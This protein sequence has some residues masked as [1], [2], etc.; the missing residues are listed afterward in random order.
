[1][2]AVGEGVQVRRHGRGQGLALTGLHLGDV[3]LVQR[4][5][6][7]HL[8]VEVPLPDRP[9]RGLPDARERLGQQV[10][11]GLPRLEPLPELGRLGR[12][13][14][15][16]QVLDLGLVRVDQ[17]GCL[18][19]LLPLAAFAELPELLDDHASPRRGGVWNP[20]GTGGLEP[21]G[22]R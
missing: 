3:A 6:A 10:V 9:P 16:G 13:L 1:V 2:H 19:E 18:S 15:V 17:P 20:Y 4:D 12:E 7:H 22:A 8:D 14:G 11:E 5:R 21:D